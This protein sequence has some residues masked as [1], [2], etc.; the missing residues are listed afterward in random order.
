MQ[1]FAYLLEAQ[2]QGVADDALEALKHRLE[3]ELGEHLT[4]WQKHVG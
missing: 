4:R 3:E 1:A 2:D